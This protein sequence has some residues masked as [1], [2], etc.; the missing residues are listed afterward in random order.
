MS[1]AGQCARLGGV[2]PAAALH[3]LVWCVRARA[4]GTRRARGRRRHS[5]ES[6][7]HHATP[8][9]PAL[10]P[11]RADVGK[12]SNGTVFDQSARFEFKI[13]VGNVI[14]VRR[15]ADRPTRAP[16]PAPRGGG[17]GLHR[18]AA[19][20]PCSRPGRSHLRHSRPHPA[21]CPAPTTW[22]RR[23]GLGR[24]CDGHEGWGQAHAGHPPVA[25]VRRVA[26]SAPHTPAHPAPRGAAARA[27]LRAACVCRADEG[28][29]AGTHDPLA[30]HP[31]LPPTL[32]PTT[33][34]LLQASRARRP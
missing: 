9:A 33:I 11:S 21:T 7:P 34:S 17:W 20:A 24:R 19:P 27:L 10:R 26:S 29:G 30:A 1:C 18:A 28:E 8:R 5:G 15:A 31:P 2:W 16:A 14:K 6:G 25:R 12:L 13:G 32:P 3:R 23:A 4:L 22:S